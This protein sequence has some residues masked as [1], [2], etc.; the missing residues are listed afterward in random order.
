M[1]DGRIEERSKKHTTS[2]AGKRFLPFLFSL[3][4]SLCMVFGRCLDREGSVPFRHPGLWAAVVILTA[5]GTLLTV[6]LWK[7]LSE[8]GK[9]QEKQIPASVTGK[10]F[11]VTALLI[12]LCYLPVFLGEYPGFFVYDAQDELMQVVTRNFSA[13]HPLLHVLLLGG[14]IQLVHKISGSYNL[15]IACYTLF[16]MGVMSC[17]FS[18]G[19]C[20]LRKEGM[21]RG[22]SFLMAIYLGLFPTVVMFVLCSAKDGLF[23][24]MLFLQVLMIREL[25]KNPENF[26]REKRYVI[27][28]AVSSVLMMLLR[29]NGFYAFFVFAALFLLLH[30]VTGLAGFLRKTALL[31]AGILAAYLLLNK[32]LVFVLH[33][34]T[35]ENQEMLTVP[36]Q[37]MARVYALEEDS[38]TQEQKETLYE[39]LPEEAL[40]HYTPKLSDPVKISFNN[41]AYEKNPGKYLKLW[42]QIGVKHPFAYLNAWFMTSYGFWYPDTVIDVYRGNTVFTF[43]YGDSSYFGYEVEQPGARHSLIPVI[44]RFYRWLSL[45]PAIQKVPVLKWLFSPGA[46][47]WVMLFILGYFGYAGYGKKAV[48][49]FLPLLVFM[50]VLL[51]PTYLVR[52]VVF[53]WVLLPV[54]FF[55]LAERFD[56]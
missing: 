15:G 7:L 21:S 49:Y 11:A 3:C 2:F 13:H 22:K 41:D 10:D 18:Y 39:I 17:I 12:F 47:L 52:Y 28:F 40:S 46:L 55:E 31:F 42:A 24:G 43:T 32:G 1:T 48:C 45:D 26:F 51:G 53:W 50:T 8:G 44:D 38:L 35:S 30:R 25:V 54:L 34:D 20:H 14:I 6:F 23:T 37:Q 4:F 19:I 33:A 9:R 29:H 56:N 36:I 16:Q 27:L 5:A